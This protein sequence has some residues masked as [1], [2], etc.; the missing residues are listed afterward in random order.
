MSPYFV[1]DEFIC[2]GKYYA[3]KLQKK[4][5]LLENY[6]NDLTQVDQEKHAFSVFQHP[7]IVNM[8]YAFQTESLA[9]MAT[10]LATQVNL[11]NILETSQLGRYCFCLCLL[12]C[13]NYVAVQ[14]D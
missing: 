9:I 4:K 10:A 1:G 6:K 12:R 8:D 5:D 2:V 13:P 3:M 11:K 14:N 7:F